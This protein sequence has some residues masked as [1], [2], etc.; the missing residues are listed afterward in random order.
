MPCDRR[1][2]SSSTI[3]PLRAPRGSRP[4]RSAADREVGVEARPR[5]AVRVEERDERLLELVAGDRRRAACDAS[6]RRSIATS[7]APRI[8]LEQVR[9]RERLVSRRT[10]ASFKARSS[11]RGVDDRREVEQRPRRPRSPESRSTAVT[12]S[13]GSGARWPT[14]PCRGPN[15]RGRVTSGT[16]LGATARSPELRRRPVAQHRARPAG[17]HRRHPSTLAASRL[18]MPDRVDAAVER[19]AAPRV[20][21]APSIALAAHPQRQRAAAAR[22]PRAAARASSATARSGRELAGSRSVFA[23]SRRLCVGLGEHGRRC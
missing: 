2:P 3:E 23:R 19:S 16:E 11:C 15:C 17:Q 1:A 8:P 9:Q 22:R 12:S 10:S 5:Q 7:P 13:A 21:P 20:G 4:R 6:K 18:A 14:M